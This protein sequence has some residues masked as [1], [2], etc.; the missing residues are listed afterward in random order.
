MSSPE[1]S[2]APQL[3]HDLRYFTCKL[4]ADDARMLVDLLKLAIAG[5]TDSKGRGKAA[6]SRVLFA[7]TKTYKQVSGLSH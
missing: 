6:I 4:S 5:R 2:P 3:Y 1:P 7:L